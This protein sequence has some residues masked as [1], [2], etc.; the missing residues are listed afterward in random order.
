LLT[1]AFWVSPTVFIPSKT[2]ISPLKT[3]NFFYKYFK[4]RYNEIK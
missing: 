2:E 1:S 3:F 4:F